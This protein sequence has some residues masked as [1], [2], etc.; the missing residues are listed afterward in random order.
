MEPDKPKE[1]SVRLDKWLK[2]SR[3]CKTR[4]IASKMCENGKVK[5]NDEKAKPA[6]LVKAGDKLT[7][8][9]K[10]N[11]RNFDILEIVQKGVSNKD[12]K[13]LYHEHKLEV[14]DESKELYAVLQDW[15]MRGKRKY[16][17]R[18]TKKERRDIDKIR[19]KEL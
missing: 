17:G 12:A 11:Y 2:F 10:S 1:Q 16:K 7:L 4:A 13:N 18:P 5:V 8:K 15:D 19:G 6:R 9:I 14:S 3:I